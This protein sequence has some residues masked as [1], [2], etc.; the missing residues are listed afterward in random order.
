MLNGSWFILTDNSDN[1]FLLYVLKTLVYNIRDVCCLVLW[2]R[3]QAMFL[4]KCMN[5]SLKYI[6][7]EPFYLYFK[8]YV[9]RQVHFNCALSRWQRMK[10]W[11]LSAYTQRPTDVAYCHILSTAKDQSLVKTRIQTRKE[12]DTASNLS[13]VEHCRTKLNKYSVLLVKSW[14]FCLV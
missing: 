7:F 8:H 11:I 13:V 2:I 3:W 6:C 12:L 4:C 1:Y 9:L 10:L 5:L 14:C